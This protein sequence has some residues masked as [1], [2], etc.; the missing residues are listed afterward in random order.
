MFESGSP[1]LELPEPRDLGNPTSDTIFPIANVPYSVAKSRETMRGRLAA[2]SF[3]LFALLVIILAVA[4]VSGLR[5]WDQM[6]G[7]A[8]SIL[9]VVVSVVGATTGFYFGSK[10][11]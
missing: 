1:M 7:L 4:V 5:T 10:E 6:Q 2:W 9:P 3:A 8:T 11:A